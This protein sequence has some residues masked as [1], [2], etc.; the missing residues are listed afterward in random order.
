MKITVFTPTY[1]RAYIIQK[2]YHS[3][4]CQTFQDFEW[5]IVDD[6]STDHTEALVEEWMREDNTFPIRYFKKSNGGKCRAINYGIDFA[7]GELFFNVDSDDYLTDDAL[8]KINKWEGTI[9]GDRRFCGVVG[10]L[11]TAPDETSNTP[12]IG[13]YRDASLLERYPEYTNNPIDGERAFIFYTEILTKYKYPEFEGEIYLRESISW[14]RMANAGYIVRVFGDIIW[15]Y[16]YL[17]DGLTISGKDK[18]LKNPKGYGLW[19]KERAEFC[20]YSLYQKLKMYCSFYHNFS[21]YYTQKEIA[22]FIGAPIGFIKFCVPIS[23]VKRLFDQ[24]IK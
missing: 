13:E 18:F 6:G 5:L 17:P 23:K 2:L 9:A 3:L 12:I 21:Q 1:N 14:N 10:N 19:W 16:K 4:Q 20:H 11:G 15:I 7:R 8:E 22:G 24:K